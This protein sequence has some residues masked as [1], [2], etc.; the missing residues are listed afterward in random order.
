VNSRLK[1]LFRNGRMFDILLWPFGVLLIQGSTWN[2][3]EM[4]RTFGQG[5]HFERSVKSYNYLFVYNF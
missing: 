1:L 5:V 2:V 3:P 4:L